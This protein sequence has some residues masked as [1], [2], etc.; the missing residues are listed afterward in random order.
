MPVLKK[1]KSLTF[2]G[3][4]YASGA[5]SFKLRT[6]L[7]DFSNVEEIGDVTIKWWGAISDFSGL[8]KAVPSL[9][10]TTWNVLENLVYNPTYQDMVDGKYT[11][12]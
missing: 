7:E 3:S 5:S 10:S 8:K 12:E 11:K 4:S 6:N 1:I 9:T 2:N